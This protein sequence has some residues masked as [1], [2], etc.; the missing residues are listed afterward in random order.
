MSHH[1]VSFDNVRYRYPSG[2]E[3]LKGVSFLITHGE[4]VG[5]VGSNGAGKSTLILHVNGLLY[6]T[7]GTVNIGD[8]PV[9]KSTLSIIRQKV[10]VVFQ[11]ADDQLFMPTVEED[12]AFGPINMG[13]PM[14][15]VKRRVEDSLVA[16][17]AEHLRKSTTYRLSGGQKRS[18]AIATVLAMGPE[19]LVLDE[20]SSNLDP[21]ARRLLIRQMEGF[22]HTCI[23]A[24]HDLDMIWELCPRTIVMKNGVVA[25]D[26]PT[27]LLLNDIPLME[28]CGLEQPNLAKIEMLMKC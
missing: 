2:S 13:L 24:S 3:A 6:P 27:K 4:K 22:S 1:Y 23:V 28:S 15:E 9:E 8:V 10:G 26:G 12:V 25:A 19:V 21:H 11:N 5:L 14:S 18:V 16:V 17:G 7:S 20:P